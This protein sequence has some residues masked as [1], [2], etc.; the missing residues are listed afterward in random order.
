MTE[1]V[2]AVVLDLE[3]YEELLETERWLSC[4]EAVGL[5]NWDGIGYA[6]N[7]FRQD[8]EEATDE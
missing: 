1:K 2:N 7:L 8:T 5:D 4:L 6:S 3:R